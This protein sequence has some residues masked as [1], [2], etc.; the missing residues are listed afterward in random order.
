MVWRTMSLWGWLVLAMEVEEMEVMIF[1]LS[2]SRTMRRGLLS[3][4]NL[5]RK[6]ERSRWE[7]QTKV[8]SR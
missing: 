3:S 4:E 5:C 8:L 7:R 1:V 2:R 6:K